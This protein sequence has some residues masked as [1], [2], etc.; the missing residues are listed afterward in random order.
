VL[1][2]INSYMNADKISIDLDSKTGFIENGS[3]YYYPDKYFKASKIQ[4][5]GS[6]NYM[7]DNATITGCEGDNPDWSLVQNMRRLSM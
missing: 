3:G 5:L 2:D 1:N 6:N 4:R 7:L